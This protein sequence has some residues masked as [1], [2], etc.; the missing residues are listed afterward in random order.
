MARIVM[1]FGGTSVADL[2]RIYNVARHVKREVEAGNQV[3]VVVSAMSGKTNEL[4]DWVQNMPKVC[5]ASSPFYDAREYDTIV[6]SGEQVTSGLL[7]IALQ[8]IG[9][10]A[11]SWQGWQIPI[12]TDN[13]HGAARIQEIDGSQIIR[14]ME[15]G[16]VAVVAGFQGIGPDNRVATLG[17]GGS[18]TSAVAVAAA[19][20]ADRCDIYTDVDGVYTTDPRIEPKARRL[21][22]ISF[23]EML[24]MASLGAKVLQVRSVELAMVHKVRTF[25]RSSFTDPDAPGMGD[26]INPPGTLICD[27]EEIVEQQVV[28]GIA[29]AKD[30]A[31][32]SL[33]RVADRPGV[34]AAI[35]GPLAEEHI[36]VDMIVQNVSEDGSKTDM[37]FTIPTGDID[38][39][40]KVLD[41][42]KSEISFDNIQSETGLAKISVIGIGMRSHAGVAATAFKALAEKGINIRAI[43]TSEIKISILIDGPYA[44]LAVRTLHAVYGLDK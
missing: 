32:I 13:A 23:E 34:S 19:V 20:K 3:A 9:V 11:R 4:V 27:E 22:K 42:A 43:T 37:T 41:K 28:T 5:G 30:E 6:A 8:S 15:M 31:Q 39:A 17:R 25:V 18:D 7:A 1:K 40:L 16:Q 29:F 12:Q 36:N 24:E 10:D 33:R 44:E 21:P 38:K 2:E 35:F 26:P 14:R